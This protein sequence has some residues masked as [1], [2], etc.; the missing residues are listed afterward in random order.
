M[1]R[2]P[3]NRISVK[4]LR[5]WRIY[6][7]IQTL[8]VLLLGIGTGVINYFTGNY[9]WLYIV[10]G[11]VVLL[12]G[13][14]LIYLFPKVRWSRWRYEVRD[15]EIELQHGLFVVKRTLVPMVRVQ[16]VDTEQGPILRKYDLA[17]ITIST[18]ATSHTIPALI[19]EEADELRGR[20]SVLARVAEEDV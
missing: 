6:G 20:I 4:G 14:L 11:A 16:H 13:Y 1:R 18:A 17:S 7:I 9:I 3:I 10:A 5:V 19:T 15:Q 2:E 8:I 12:V